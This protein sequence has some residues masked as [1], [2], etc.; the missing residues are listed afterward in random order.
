MNVFEFFRLELKAARRKNLGISTESTNNGSV[1]K[2]QQLEAC[3]YI[4]LF[5][6]L[7]FQV[8]EMLMKFTGVVTLE[9]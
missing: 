1:R 6:D 2:F 5:F 3:I 8:D 7:I 9:T 4:A